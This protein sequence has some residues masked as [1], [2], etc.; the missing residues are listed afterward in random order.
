MLRDFRK[1]AL[2]KKDSKNLEKF[3]G[4][5]SRKFYLETHYEKNQ[6]YQYLYFLRSKGADINSFFDQKIEQKKDL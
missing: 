6:L 3:L 4:K 5:K 2:E 1:T